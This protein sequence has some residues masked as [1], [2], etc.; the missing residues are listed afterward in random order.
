MSEKQLGF[1]YAFLA[2]LAVMVYV[3]LEMA[4]VK[5]TSAEQYADKLCSEL[6]GPQVG[7]LWK[8]GELVCQA[9]NGKILKIKE[10]K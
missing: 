7:S 2:F 5:P 6:Y 4:L 8:D 3:A 9:Q 10:P 1:M